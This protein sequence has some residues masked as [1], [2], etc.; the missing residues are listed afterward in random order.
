VQ[1]VGFEFSS[2][3]F[4]LNSHVNQL[5]HTCLAFLAKIPALQRAGMI[6]VVL[7]VGGWL[8]WIVRSAHIQR[9]A[10]G[11]IGGAGGLVQYDW[12]WREGSGVPRG[13]RRAPTWLVDLIGVD[14]SGRV[15][16]VRFFSLSK[17]TDA[18]FVHVGRLTQL[19]RLHIF[20]SSLGDA[21]MAHLKGLTNL[22][23]LDLS[24]TEVSE[25]GL[26]NLKDLIHLRSPNLGTTP[27]TDAGLA[28]LKGLTNLVLR[29][30]QCTQVTDV[31]L[32]HLKVLTNLGFLNLQ[33]T[34]VTDAGLAHLRGLT[35]LKVLVLN[36]AEVSTA[37]IQELNQA[38]SACMACKRSG[39]RR[40]LPFSP[41]ITVQ[42]ASY[43]FCLP[44]RKPTLRIRPHATAL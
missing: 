32:A 15:T 3:F 42:K 26:A 14:Y 9:D 23:I 16:D 37:G 21:E 1:S 8:G 11:A 5:G 44:D 19:E 10:V 22:H 41:S 18:T 13:K 6:V 31:G 43:E 29:H 39:V 4:G 24:Y 25:A 12:E 33:R 7:V 40:I 35:N 34:Q 20:R 28:H 27:V 17:A 2:P 30:L 38:R 36:G